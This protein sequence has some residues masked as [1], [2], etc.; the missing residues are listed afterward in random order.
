[1]HAL[2]NVQ[3]LITDGLLRIGELADDPEESFSAEYVCPLTGIDDTLL[4][5]CLPTG[6]GECTAYFWR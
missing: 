6:R 1:V 4:I 5:A 3:A 2:C